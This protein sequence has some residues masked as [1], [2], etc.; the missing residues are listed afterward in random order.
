MQYPYG[1]SGSRLMYPC[2]SVS[3]IQFIKGT[4]ECCMLYL[5]Q[6]LYNPGTLTSSANWCVL[7][8]V[9]L[10]SHLSSK[11]SVFGSMLPF[12]LPSLEHAADKVAA[13]NDD[14]EILTV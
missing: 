8:N 4:R 14:A 9:Y 6:Y 11:Q 1:P 7:G 10:R 5:T 2:E 13:G 12:S 3:E